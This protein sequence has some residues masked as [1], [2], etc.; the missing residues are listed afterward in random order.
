[1]AMADILQEQLQG[2]TSDRVRRD[3]LMVGIEAQVVIHHV[4]QGRS[5]DHIA[6]HGPSVEV[7]IPRRI[8]CSSR[9]PGYGL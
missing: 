8:G 9:T 5:I 7:P 1:M 3:E 6:G 2:L 4:Q